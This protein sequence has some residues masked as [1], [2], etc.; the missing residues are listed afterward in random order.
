ME[1]KEVNFN[2]AKLLTVRE[3]EKIYVGVAYICNSLRMTDGQKKRQI[4]K[5]QSDETLKIGVKKLSIKID[6]QVREQ[7]FIELDYLP[8]WLAKIN[9]ARFSKELK[10]KLLEYQLH[11]KDVLAAAF[12]DNKPKQLTLPKPKE[13]KIIKKY[14]NGVPVMSIKDL[15]VILRCCE[16]NI[17]AKLKNKNLIHKNEIANFK[18]ENPG[19]APSIAHI[20]ILY[21][22][23]VINICKKMGVYNKVKPQ[24][25]AYF[26]DFTAEPNIVLSESQEIATD[27]NKKAEKLLQVLPYIIEESLKN[28]VAVEVIRLI[29]NKILEEYENG[30]LSMRFI[31]S[32]EKI[33]ETYEF[34]NFKMTLV[35]TDKPIEEFI[36]PNYSVSNVLGNKL[37]VEKIK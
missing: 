30:R 23:E 29:D 18:K 2:G 26:D 21:R 16:Q 17:H 22:E 24:I 25:L 12:L 14:Y 31:D 3:N 11:A 13:H 6:T 35:E 19:L 7:I 8:I 20:T 10:D 37:I 36:S 28:K 34:K 33:I 1:R 32:S 5:V 15:S 9:P 27:K 4:L